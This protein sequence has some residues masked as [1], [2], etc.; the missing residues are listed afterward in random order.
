V[1]IAGGQLGLD[2]NATKGG[3]EQASAT[4][5]SCAADTMILTATYASLD[6]AVQLVAITVQELSQISSLVEDLNN[7]VADQYSLTDVQIDDV[8]FCLGFKDTLAS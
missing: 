5:P 2:K 4:S 8:R 6:Q 7:R 1:F 3:G